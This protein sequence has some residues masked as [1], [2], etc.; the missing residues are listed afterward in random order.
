[1]QYGWPGNVRELRNLV[2]R[3]MVTTRGDEIGTAD[4]PDN[5][6]AGGRVEAPPLPRSNEELKALK[7]R[8]HDQ[9]SAELE[10]AF[11][12]DALRRSDW[13][14]SRA[15]RETGLLRPNFHALMRKHGIRAEES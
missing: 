9:A 14:V 10:R 4:L 15:A 6:S 8:L 13:N 3:L 7:R 5:V 1:M 2:E 12:L 11:L